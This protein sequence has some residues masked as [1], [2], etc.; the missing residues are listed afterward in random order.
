MND[1]YDT[2]EIRDPALREREQLAQL[3]ELVTHAKANAPY[4]SRVLADVEG[5]GPEPPAPGGG[6]KGLLRRKP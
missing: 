6:F 4:F 1:H 5:E 2:L 3:R